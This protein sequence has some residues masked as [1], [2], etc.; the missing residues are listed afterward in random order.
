MKWNLQLVK[1]SLLFIL[2]SSLLF[3]Q[4]P[5]AFNLT[6]KDGLPSNTVFQVFQDKKGFVWIAN[7]DGISRYDGFEF[8]TYNSDQQI[9]KAGSYI[10]EDKL[11]R[12]WYANFDG[13]LFYVENDNL[14]YFLHSRAVGHAPFCVSDKYLFVINY[15]GVHVYDITSLKL[16]KTIQQSLNE[17]EHVICFKNEFF[18]ISDHILYKVNEKLELSSNTYFKDKSLNAKRIVP[19][20][21]NFLVYPKHNDT[22]QFFLFSKN[23][24]FIN[25]LK[26]DEP[27]FIQGA[28]NIGNKLWVLTSNGI[29]VYELTDQKLEKV[30]S[31]FKGKDISNVMVDYQGNYWITTLYEGIYLVNNIKNKVFPLNNFQVVRM[32][33]TPNNLIL[34]TRN[35][36]LIK[37][38]YSLSRF[39]I[40]H[41]NNE[42]TS[43]NYFHYD[44]L[45]NQVV[46]SSKG[47]TVY[48]IKSKTISRF[49]N[50]ALKDLV[51]IDEKY[52]AIAASGF[53][54]LYIDPEG[55]PNF[56][57]S[58]DK[59]FEN[60]INKDYSDISN[61]KIEIRAKS[62]DYNRNQNKLVV[63]TN[64]GLFLKTP[65]N[66]KELKIN[67]SPFYA[68]KV[69]WF[70]DLIY[71]LDTKGN[72][73]KITD[74]SRFELLNPKLGLMNY[75]IKRTKKI[76]NELIIIT[77]S[78]ICIYNLISKTTEFVDFQLS[79][80]TF[81]DIER[82]ENKLL[83]LTTD[84]IV[85]INNGNKSKNEAN[86]RFLVNFISVNT[87]K[88]KW[89]NPLELESDE[90]NI[91]INFSV[92]NFGKT[93]SDNIYYRLNGRSWVL[94]DKDSRTL[95][96]SS[97]SPA[98]YNIE[99]KIGNRIVKETIRFT[100]QP[101]FWQRWWFQLLGLLFLIAIGFLFYTNRM[102]KVRNQ[103]VL[104]Q[105][106][107]NLEQSLSKSI[108]TAIKSQMNPHF[109]YNALNT[110]QAFI[111]TND[112]KQA[113]AYLAKFAKLTRTVLEMSE[114]DTI[115]LNEEF[116]AL[117]LYLELEKMRFSKNFNYLLHTEKIANPNLIEIPPMLIQPYV[118]NAIKHGLLH[119]KGERKLKIYFKLLSNNQLEVVIDDNGIGRKQSGE[120]NQMKNE[121]HTSFATNANKKRLEILNVK[122]AD[123]RAIEII[124]KYDEKGEPIGTK[125]ILN[126]QTS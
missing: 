21:D 123:I 40:I 126:I 71:A 2:N 25:T 29:L 34:S 114:R 97:L 108:L 117:N 43:I 41:Q 95:L 98:V 68:E 106:K 88:R 109:F 94:I 27:S 112:T 90:N 17:I 76:N 6:H 32:L 38:D 11:G 54:G 96:F 16:I 83:I 13:Q 56:Q 79:N 72:L 124:D 47:F 74:N 80:A 110:I 89:K 35:G 65:A 84:G 61:F 125:V 58:W 33:S 60:Q 44:P 53:Y 101:P 8:V 102:K 14:H 28:R 22:K 42:E 51:R 39:E 121:K 99:F 55:N 104:L 75:E 63:A 107:V 66:E 111:F 3:S 119:R 91:S 59:A 1:L 87:T 9:S 36:K 73:Y 30:N 118:E 105:E 113:N 23:L 4:E 20:N 50:I 48:S 67:N 49:Y 24:N 62:I 15:Q 7:Q 26:I 81:L 115:T 92:I 120:L 46:Y 70:N 64:E 77:N 78:R 86:E 103:I 85:E 5:Y 52:F 10:S 93:I 69:C 116:T 122:N 57:S 19:F 31:F 82:K 100:I 18:Y 45:K 37:G 12:I